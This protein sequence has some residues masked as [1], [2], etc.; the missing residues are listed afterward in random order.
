MHDPSFLA[1]TIPAPWLRFDK[2]KR[3]DAPNWGVIVRRRTNAENLGERVY[4][5]YRPVGYDVFVA[6]RHVRST[7]LIEIW[8]DE[9]G[10][11]DMRTVCKEIHPRGIRWAWKHRAHLRW[12]LMPWLNVRRRFE[13]CDECHR[14]MWKA[15]RFGTGWDSTGVLH[16]ECHLLRCERRERLDL[17]K[18]LSGRATWTENWRAE[19]QVFAWI[20][21]EDAK[22][23]AK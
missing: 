9:P 13:R 14:R 18:H 1:Y 2:W 15:T 11:G 4:P 19:R 5:W 7:T 21:R 23:H 22:E 20:E 6:G 3:K 16:S 8:H 12:K 10:G 17:L